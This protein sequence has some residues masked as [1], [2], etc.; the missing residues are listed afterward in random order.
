MDREFIE[1]LREQI[2]SLR[3]ERSYYRTTSS[4]ST[5]SVDYIKILMEMVNVPDLVEV[6]EKKKDHLPD[7]LFEV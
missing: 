6:E 2:E 3:E 4:A 5:M 1:Q 7:D